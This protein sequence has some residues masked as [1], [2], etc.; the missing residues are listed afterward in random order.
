MEGD[1]SQE[2]GEM[3]CRRVGKDETAEGGGGS[4]VISSSIV[5]D[6][7]WLTIRI[8]LNDQAVG[9]SDQTYEDF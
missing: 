5:V 9:R 1:P 6:G 4:W 2:S 7:I 8:S 3:C